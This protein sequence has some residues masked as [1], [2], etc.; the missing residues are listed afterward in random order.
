MV[1]P[2]VFALLLCALA[3]VAGCSTVRPGV[4]TESAPYSSRKWQQRFAFI[5]HTD[6]LHHEADVPFRQLVEQ[7]VTEQLTYRGYQLDATHPEFLIAFH[8]FDKTTDLDFVDNQSVRRATNEG[9]HE[10]SE[11][12]SQLTTRRHRIGRGNVLLQVVN[13][14]NG[15]LV[16]QGYSTRPRPLRHESE[17]VNTR[18]LVQ[19]VIDRFPFQALGTMQAEQRRNR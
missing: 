14:A 11:V 7:V 12:F 4:Q 19:A 6:S 9:I 1:R 5:R 13:V 8:Q 17:Q 15:Q 3:L 16:W 2:A 10:S 18:Y